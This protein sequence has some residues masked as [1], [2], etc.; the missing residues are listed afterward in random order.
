MNGPVWLALHHE[1]RGDGVASD[2]VDM[3]QHARKL[4]DKY[5][6]NIAL[7][8]IL[9]GWDFLQRGGS[10]RSLPHACWHGVDIMG[11]DSY[12]PWAAGN[13][14]AWKSVPETM[15]PGLT[16]QSWGYPTLVAETGLHVDSANPGR[17]ADLAA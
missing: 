10:P 17:A 16:I 6:S 11:F 2:W 15:S 1:P 4:I 13:G 7:V 14:Q 12:N 3:Q 9:N 5:S 8:G